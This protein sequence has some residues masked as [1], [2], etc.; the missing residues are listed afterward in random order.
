VSHHLPSTP[1][2]L[3]HHLLATIP[4]VVTAYGSYCTQCAKQGPLACPL[5]VVMHKSWHICQCQSREHS[6]QDGIHQWVRYY[7]SG[8]AIAWRS[9][10]QPITAQNISEAE[11]IGGNVASKVVKCIRMVLTDLGFPPT[12]PPRIWEDNKSV[13]KIVNHDCPTPQSRHIAIHYLGLQQWCEL[14]ELILIH[15]AGTI[16]PSDALT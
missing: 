16:N 15:V 9:K 14:G 10:T 2:R 8:G 3:G 5:A 1:V 13:L 12:G 7:F 4:R 6:H 11:L